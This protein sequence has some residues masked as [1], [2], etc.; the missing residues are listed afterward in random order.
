VEPMKYQ[1]PSTKTGLRPEGG[2]P[3]DKPGTHPQGGSPKDK[4]GTHPQGGDPKDKSQYMRRWVL[5]SYQV[6]GFRCQS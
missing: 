2:S 4:P 1:T 6:S 3:K 5:F